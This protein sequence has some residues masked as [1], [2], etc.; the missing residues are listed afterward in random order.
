MGPIVDRT[1]EHLCD[2]DLQIIQARKFLLE[3]VRSVQEDRE[4]PGV[5]PS[6]YTVRA[7]E[8]VIDDGKAWRETL[9]HLYNPIVP[10]AK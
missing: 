10:H 5:Q 2:A 9:R 1:Q 4:P 6:Y 8:R 3:A 7:S